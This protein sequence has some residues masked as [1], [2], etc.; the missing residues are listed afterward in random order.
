M[1]QDTGDKDGRKSTE[2]LIAAVLM[3]S[4]IFLVFAI[5]Y[6]VFSYSLKNDEATMQANAKSFSKTIALVAD[7]Y[8]KVIINNVR[9]DAIEFTHNY[10]TIP[11]SIPL[12]ATFT[13]DLMKYLNDN[14]TTA[15]FR[16]KSEFP[17]PW[18]KGLT[19]NDFERGAIEAFKT[20]SVQSYQR[21]ETIDGELRLEYATPVIMKQRCVTCHNASPNSPKND[22]QIGDVRGI[23]IVS[24]PE[25]SL[26]KSEN[27]WLIYLFLA[28]SAFLFV[29][30]TTIILLYN[31]NG[32]V[33]KDLEHK[34]KLLTEATA[35]INESSN[36]A[37]L[38][39]MSTSVA[40]E[41]NQP[42]HVIRMAAGNSRRKISKG[43]AEL[44]YL[45]DKLERIE[46]QTARAAAIIG[47][48]QMFGPNAKEH[49]ELVDA[50]IVVTNAL[51]LM[52][53]QLRLS[54]IEIV[55]ELGEDC[56]SILGHIIQMEQVILNLLTNAS[57][58]MAENDGDAKIT[59]R[60]FEDDKG[61]HITSEDTGGG[62]PDDVLPRIFEPF[63]T[64]KEM[65]KG[66]GL[67]LSASYGIVRDMNGTIVAENIGEGARFTITLPTVS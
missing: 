48:R 27:S 15:E 17:F 5:I 1:I 14:S 55:T 40:H 2:I 33:V 20:T 28:F 22:W 23:R 49:P 50:R 52:G 10:K 26:I 21:F 46:E 57:D 38:G 7:F 56:P 6:I 45:N 3:I 4:S 63:Y 19:L 58:S 43:T 62:I 35:Q 64:T 44:E 39:E 66:T 65:G 32:A 16:L 24:I 30:F 9:G 42:L 29:I 8:S 25:N 54:E 60:V 13:L 18:R 51:D 37:T 41:L 61:V 31:K 36:L 11:N 47:H 34:Q 12:P 67:G 53:E 59:L